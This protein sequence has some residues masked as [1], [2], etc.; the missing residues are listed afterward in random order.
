MKSRLARQVKE[1]ARQH[2]ADLVGIAPVSRFKRAPVG[3]HPRDIMPEAQSVIVIGICFPIGVLQGKSK[4]TA[5]RTYEIIFNRLDCCAYELS[6]F[7]EKLGARAIP[8]PADFPYEF[9]DAS[10]QEGRGELSHRHDAVLAG[11]GCL[12]KNSLLLTPE[13]GNRVNLT[14]IVTDLLLEGDLLSQKQLCIPSCRL[15]IEVCPASAFT[16]DGTVNQKRCRRFHTI[17]TPRGFK[18]FACWKCRSVCPVG[19]DLYKVHRK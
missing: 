13:F 2:G 15:C 3:F 5:T 19:G 7:I 1:F 10:K 9:W 6:L 16:G 17:V 12:G 11:F 4:G 18:L 14:S 8:V